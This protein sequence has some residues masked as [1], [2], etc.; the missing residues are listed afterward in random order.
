MKLNIFIF[1]ILTL[2]ILPVFADENNSSTEENQS[3]IAMNGSG[4]RPRENTKNIECYYINGNIYIEFSEPEGDT[5]L[6]ITNQFNGESIHTSFSATCLYSIYI[7]TKTGVY[8]ISIETSSGE[9]Y[10]GYLQI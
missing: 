7:G 3:N 6:T 5:T 10:I 9:K 1:T 4:I 8:E 2:C